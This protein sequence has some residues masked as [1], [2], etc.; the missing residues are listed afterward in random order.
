MVHARVASSQRTTPFTSQVVS[1]EGSRLHLVFGIVLGAAALLPQ[2]RYQSSNLQFFDL[3]VAGAFIMLAH[4]GEL[5]VPASLRRVIGWGWVFLVALA[6]SSIR[7]PDP[8]AAVTQLL[9]W[10]FI[11]CIVLPTC[12]SVLRF[13]QARRGAAIAILCVIAVVAVKTIGDGAADVRRFRAWRSTSI[14]DSPQ[15]AA[16]QVATSVPLVFALMRYSHIFTRSRAAAL[17]LRISAWGLFVALLYF[18]TLNLSRSG[19][20]ASFFGLATF[21]LANSFRNGRPSARDMLRFISLALVLTIGVTAYVQN[22]APDNV[23]TR[24]SSVSD[25]NSSEVA[26]RTDGFSDVLTIDPTYYLVGTGPDN[27]H[28]ISE[29]EIKPH[30]A[31]LLMFAEGGVVALVGFVAVFGVSLRA[32]FSSLTRAGSGQEFVML[33][34]GA[35]S[36]V[37]YIVI[38]TFNTQG[39]LRGYWFYLSIGLACAS[40]VQAR[41]TGAAR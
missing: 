3:A 29:R 21:E 11:F 16:F 7:S 2:L 14:Y 18:F 9:Q 41:R 15:V 8:I 17:A 22:W 23:V 19:A 38:A 40:L 31:F 6:V 36:T 26:G 37:A 28:R 5:V 4:R 33:A 1:P 34:V 13:E 30:N 25:L 39:I 20:L 35:G 10:A 12:V 24:I 27:Y 32:M